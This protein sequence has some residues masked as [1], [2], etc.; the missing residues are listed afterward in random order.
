LAICFYLPN[1]GQMAWRFQPTLDANQEYGKPHIEQVAS[2]VGKLQKWMEWKS[3]RL[4]G[5]IYGGLLFILLMYLASAK[6]SEFLYFQ[7]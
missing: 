3:T 1:T 6:K 4:Q 2:V 5:S 7:F